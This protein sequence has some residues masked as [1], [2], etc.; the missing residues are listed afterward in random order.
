MTRLL[1]LEAFA[2]NDI[3]LGKK[4]MPGASPVV[5]GVHLPELVQHGSCR[6]GKVF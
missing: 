6:V 2:L 1:R 3:C 4:P 5:A